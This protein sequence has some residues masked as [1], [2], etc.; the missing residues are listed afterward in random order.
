MSRNVVITAVVIVLLA[1]VGWYLTRPKQPATQTSQP[2]ET[3][4]STESVS[5]ATATDEAMMKEK[6]IVTV[7]S[8]GFTPKSI[9]V[10]VGDTVTWSNS[11]T[12][13]HTVNSDSHPTHTLY[14]ILNKV[15]QIKAAEKKALQFTQPGTYNYHDHL[16]PSLTGLVTVQ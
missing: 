16:N 3:P 12:I 15:G 14:P 1:V 5:P 11:D 10:K 13:T 4:V 7:S 2:T 8:T 6:N 9:T